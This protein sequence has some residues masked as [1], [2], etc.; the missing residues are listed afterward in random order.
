MG[1]REALFYCL[2]KRKSANSTL[3]GSRG[4]EGAA[5]SAQQMAALDS[6]LKRGK[7]SHRGQLQRS[8][9]VIING[10]APVL[11]G[12]NDF[13]FYKIATFCPWRG[14]VHGRGHWEPWGLR[15]R[16]RV[17]DCIS[18]TGD[19]KPYSITFGGWA[20]CRLLLSLAVTAIQMELFLSSPFSLNLSLWYREKRTNYSKCLCCIIISPLMCSP[21]GC[22][23][24]KW[25]NPTGLSQQRDSKE[26]QFSHYGLFLLSRSPGNY[27]SLDLGPFSTIAYYSGIPCG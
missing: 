5:C 23:Y 21:L 3:Q 26:T 11:V 8:E 25:L 1:K 22:S 27:L 12:T 20:P 6:Q 19:V 9:T 4:Q 16:G 2:L 13:P 14:C 10:T 18:E 17:P 7:C 24:M 15:G